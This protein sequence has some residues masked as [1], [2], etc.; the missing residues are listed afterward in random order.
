MKQK[1][2]ILMAILGIALVVTGC[3]TF[4]GDQ[5]KLKPKALERKSDVGG[6]EMNI[7]FSNP[8]GQGKNGYLTF[9]V[10]MDNH[11][12]NLDEYEFSDYAT[13]ID[14]KGNSPKGNTTW[15]VTGGGGHHVINTLLFPDDSFITP[16]TKYIKL[17][18]KD[19]IDVPAREFIWEN[20]F[21]GIKE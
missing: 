11:S 2:I 6:L 3:S 1:I 7:I 14:D 16:D 10:Q 18:I 21:L 20:E 15:E 19:F 4:D 8:L 9:V 5:N 12:Y 13:L 17:V